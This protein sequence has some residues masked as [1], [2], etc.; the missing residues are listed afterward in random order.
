VPRYSP[1]ASPSAT[2]SA[3][4]KW[5][6]RTKKSFGQHFLIDDGVV[7]KILRLADPKPGDVLLEIGCGI[8]TLTEALLARGAFVWGVEIDQRFQP[9]L[10]DLASRWQNQFS[11]LIADALTLQANDLP[12]RFDIV[13]NLPYNIAAT[14]ILAYFQRFPGLQSA[15]VM[16]QS[17]VADRI[18]AVPD[19]KAY[20]AYSVKLALLAD[21]VDGFSV[22][23]T[24][25]IPPPRVDSTVLRL[26][27]R[28]FS[29][30]E[31]RSGTV[32]VSPALTR[33]II[34][35]AFSKRRK[36]I[37]NSLRSVLSDVL[38]ADTLSLSATEQITKALAVAG[39]DGSRRAESLS[40]DEFIE[41]ITAFAFLL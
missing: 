29:D 20:G 39:I 23:R 18:R 28:S 24:S 13:A 2:I 30:A 26:E 19:S 40:L 4:Q 11:F 10:N 7:G 35:A 3:L 12:E 31:S 9:I 5:G 27:R 33:L 25:F 38:S 32:P 41:L 37:Y 1:L 15:T 36:T 21:T 8:G 22:A 16:I 34:D 14:V 6:L 17:E